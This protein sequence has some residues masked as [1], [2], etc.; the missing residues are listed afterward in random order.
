MV[1]LMLTIQAIPAFQDN[2]IWII[3]AEGSS[4]VLIIDPGEAAPVL[5]AIKQQNLIPV[6]ILIT[7]GCHDHVGGI[8]GVLDHFDVPVY[9]PKNEFIPHI[10][11]PLSACGGLMI[12][13]LFAEFHILDIPGHTKGHIGFLMEGNLFCGDTLFGAGCGRLH[14]GPAEVMFGSLQKIKQLPPSTTIFCAHEY[15]Q[16][17]L[18][19]ALE[20]EPENTDIQQRIEDTAALRKQNRPSIPSSLALELA[21]NPFLRCQDVET[22][23]LLRLKKDQFK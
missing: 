23:R 22:F 8:E 7:H 9:G 21:T 10:T 2:Y 16:A 13:P 12:D 1:K 3:Q 5:E 11:H 19:F 6:A 17:N 20:I 14:S 18:R 15:T 4:H